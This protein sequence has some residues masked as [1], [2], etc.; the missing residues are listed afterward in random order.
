MKTIAYVTLLCRPLLEY[1]GEVWDLF[2]VKHL[3]QIKMV[4]RRAVR[5]ISNLRGREVTSE[6]KALGLKL[7]QDRRKDARVKLYCRVI[8]TPLL[9]II[10]IAS[11]LSKLLSILM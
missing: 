3:S 2:L 7:L 8:L 6:G 10:L 5:F 9:Q 11:R 4:Q 1:A